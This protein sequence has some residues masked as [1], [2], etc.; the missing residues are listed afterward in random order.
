MNEQACAYVC[1]ILSTIILILSGY[2]MKTG[3]MTYAVISL[4]FALIVS[5]LSGF[6]L[7]C[8]YL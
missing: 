4:V 2:S 6:V 5:A 7:V 3:E 1:A 8:R